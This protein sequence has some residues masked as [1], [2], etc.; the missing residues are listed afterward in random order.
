MEPKK[1][2]KKRRKYDADFKAE[3]LKM[4]ASGQSAARISEK[5]GM[6]EN[7]VYRWK[8]E[9]I[10]QKQDKDTSLSAYPPYLQPPLLEQI[11]SLKKELEKAE[12]ERDILKKA[13][14]IFSI[15]P[16]GKNTAI[17]KSGA[18]ILKWKPCARFWA[19]AGVG[20]TAFSKAKHTTAHR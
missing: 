17:F 9:A 11:E 20:I 1:T 14:A 13:V 5:P 10:G 8:K 7:L 15:S 4:L 16:W 18:G 3:V 19:W 12:T 2:V 6:G